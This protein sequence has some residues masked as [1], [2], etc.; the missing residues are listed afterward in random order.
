VITQDPVEIDITKIYTNDTVRAAMA[1][2]T[3]NSVAARVIRDSQA[4]IAALMR[5][6]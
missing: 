2:N 6:R 5:G 3:K 1:A 4:A